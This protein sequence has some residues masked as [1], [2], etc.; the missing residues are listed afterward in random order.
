MLSTLSIDANESSSIAAAVA[1]WIEALGAA[2]VRVEES[3]LAEYGRCTLPSGTRPLAVL[4]PGSREEVQAAVRIASEW[5]VP[6]YPISRG[7]N[8]GYGDACP[9]AGGQ[10]ILDLGRMNRIVEV[11]AP[12]AYAVVEP[13]VTQGQLHGYLRERNLPLWL[14]VTGAGP[15]ASIV[16]N[17]LE[18]GFGHTPYGDHFGHSCGMEVVLADGRVLHTGFGGY[19]NAQAAHVFPWGLGPFLDGLFTQSNFGI[20]TQLGVWLLPA[21]PVCEA[22]AC[23]AADEDSLGAIVEALRPLR[24]HEIVRSSVH[25]ANDLRVLSA[26]MRYP[27]EE[28][29]GAT[30]LTP[31]MRRSLRSRHGLGAWNVLGGLYGS[32]AAVAAARS[33][34]RRALRSVAHVTFFDDRKLRRA[35]RLA[36]FLSG[37]GFGKR[38]RT[39]LDSAWPVY[40]LLQGIPSPR[41]LQG[42]AWRCRRAGEVSPSDC[43]TIWL[44]P[45]LPMTAAACREVCGIIE[46]LM[47]E[48]GFE[49]LM[50][51]TSI[52]GR[53]LCCVLNI[54]YDRDN[55]AETSRAG[56]CYDV[57]FDRLASAGYL[58]YRAGIQSMAKLERDNEVFW[59]VCARIKAAL[60]PQS[61]LAPGRY[62]PSAARGEGRVSN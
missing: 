53:A 14:D 38:L 54:C 26:R 8:W 36:D 9:V 30:P 58:P 23:A 40:E 50:T 4:R 19:S 46:P 2:H 47:T 1:S 28:M 24:L 11:N 13:G 59:D 15:D 35:S 6:L 3:V 48:R 43:G 31:E 34:V 44:A 27:W 22:F 51:V 39:I 33:E 55:P 7:R 62:Q 32:R 20:V 29:G 57:L 5:A 52:S 10:V 42:V 56:R 49:P 17:T 25:I 16:G 21:P 60:D 61:I 12:L 45:V 37:F 41:H 18:R